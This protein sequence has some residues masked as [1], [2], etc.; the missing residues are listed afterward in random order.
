M[1]HIDSY[2]LVPP[3]LALEDAPDNLHNILELMQR[4]KVSDVVVSPH[5]CI[6]FKCNGQLIPLTKKIID[7]KE[8]EKL[9]AGE[10]SE[11]QMRALKFN[12]ELNCSLHK[13]YFGRYRVSAFMQRGTVAFV[14]RFIPF[15]IPAFDTLCLPPVLCDLIMRKRGLLLITGPTGCGK[16]TTMASMLDYR[17]HVRSDHILTVED[18]IEFHFTNHNSVINQREVGTDTESFSDS[19][20]HGLRQA[21]DVIMI[22]EIRDLETIEMAMQFASSGHL[23]VASMHANNSYNAITRIAG[24]YPP[25]HRHNLY[26]NLSA[27]LSAVVSQRLVPTIE[28]S[29]LPAVEVLINTNAI[30]HLIEKGEVGAIPEMMQKSMTEGMQTFEKSLIELVLQEKISA[31]S[32]VLFSDSPTNMYMLL[33]EKKKMAVVPPGE[34]PTGPDVIVPD[35]T[36]QIFLTESQKSSLEQFA[37][38]EHDSE[39]FNSI[40]IDAR[41]V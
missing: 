3:L 26:N 9:L 24:F 25:E 22:G 10:I 5:A 20:R 23:C 11:Q 4:F 21:P 8:V 27:T 2:A 36:N 29:L 14:I 15:N 12:K 35:V 39:L 41:H 33:S 19:L 16:S 40:A 32:A 6:K 18:P 37:S 28:K 30:A 13:D 1:S 34:T 31:K 38:A 7:E 17:N